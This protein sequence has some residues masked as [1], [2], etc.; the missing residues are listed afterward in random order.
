M[1]LLSVA[2]AIVAQGWAVVPLHPRTKI[3]T[4]KEWQR[5]ASPD[6]S[7]V[8]AW[9]AERPRLNAGVATGRKSGVWVLDLDGPA[10]EAALAELE[11][12]HGPLPATYSVKSGRPEG[13]RHLYFRLPPN[14]RVGNGKLR[15]KI[16]IKGEGG[17]VVAA[18]SIHPN[19]A[20]YRAV[21]PAAP[22]ADTPPWLLAAVVA[23]TAEPAPAS[24]PRVPQLR[25]AEAT[26][27]QALRYLRERAPV[28]VQGQSGSSAC[29]A[30]MG[31]L[32]RMGVA[33]AAEAVELCEVSG[34]NARCVPPWPLDGSQGLARKFDQ[35]LAA[36]GD[37]PANRA[38]RAYAPRASTPPRSG[39]GA[40]VSPPSDRNVGGEGGPAAVGAALPPSGAPRA[41]AAEKSTDDS[42][43]ERGREEGESKDLL[44]T[45]NG[46]IKPTPWNAQKI[47][48]RDFAPV[49]GWDEHRGTVTIL[50]RPPWLP[51]E[52]KRGA[53]P[54]PLDDRDITHCGEWLQ[55][56]YEVSFKPEG[57]AAGFVAAADLNSYHP[58]RDWLD[59]L[60]WDGVPRCDDWL[61]DYMGAPNTELVR[62]FA[63]RWLISAVA[64]VFDPGCK[65]DTVLVLEGDQGLLKSTALRALTTGEPARL[66]PHSSWFSDEKIDFESKDGKMLLGGVWIIEFAEL[67]SIAK[68][69]IETIKAFVTRQ[70]DNFRFPWARLPVR[71][72]RQ[73]VYA[74][75]TNSRN[76][77]KDPTGNRRY[78]PFECSAIDIPGLLRMRAQLWAEAVHRYRAKELWYLH[79]PHLKAAHAAA[80]EERRE[81][82]PW[83]EP[84]ARW[85]ENK[86]RVT[87]AQVF[88]LLNIDLPKRTRQDEQAIGTILRQCGFT[89]RRRVRVSAT[90]ASLLGCGER[91]WMFF[92][93]DAQWTA[94][95]GAEA[96]RVAED[97]P[98]QADLL[99]AE[100]ES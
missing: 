24:A 13:G 68:A 20:E 72:P 55:D 76:Y 69:E 79:E 33:T 82:H 2:L 11:R 42:S 65:V 78:W 32:R 94:Y 96:R 56:A 86:S 70:E 53:Y 83:E 49:I 41:A 97:E 80:V 28:A 37:A 75:T 15:E 1:N 18:G 36:I 59:A 62:A 17:Q 35:S 8:S 22:V 52:A 92:R 57:V 67:G 77:L 6:R 54:L 12:L 84:I 95:A 16:D 93:D 3:P 7:V 100:R 27:E 46:E 26:R 66:G 48:K 64:R 85:V 31:T 44:R 25:D 19:G 71:R 9:W 30:V 43:R 23:A 21:D 47:M 73:C 61:T 99:D 88:N 87:S 81:T 98:R 10:G 39:G 51:A 34:W 74:A 60:A 5:L 4:T 14:V 50:R 29:M 45:R 90:E 38:R 89:V 63:A 91:P 58:I 40:A